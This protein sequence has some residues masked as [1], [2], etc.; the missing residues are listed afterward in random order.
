MTIYCS[1][2]LETFLGQ[3]IRTDI[4]TDSSGLGDWNGNLF[5]VDR[6]KCLIF[7]NNKT[8]YSIIMTNILKKDTVDFGQYF[9]ERLFKQLEYD[10][11]I[12][13]RQE[14]KLRKQLNNIVLTKSNNDKRIIGTMNHHVENLRFNDIDGGIDNWDEVEVNKMLNQ[15]P[16]GT[17]IPIEKRRYRDFFVPIDIMKELI[18]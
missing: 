18:Q 7:M 6:K 10:L 17:K 8:C 14:V 2:K 4:P 16:M 9:K 13:E 11:K 12:N 3:S 15:R 1:K 5:T